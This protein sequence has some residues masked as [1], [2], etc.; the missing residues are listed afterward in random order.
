MHPPPA[1]HPPTPPPH[2]WVKLKRDYEASLRDSLDLVVI[3]AWHGQGR[4]VGWY[5]PFL[6]AVYDP[7]AVRV[8]MVVYVCLYNGMCV[9]VTPSCFTTPM[10]P[11]TNSLSL[12]LFHLGGVSEYMSVHE[13]LH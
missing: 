8:S 11:P 4:K 12:F 7:D 13:W 9:C 2:R 3:G 10:T 6:L 1:P 5:S